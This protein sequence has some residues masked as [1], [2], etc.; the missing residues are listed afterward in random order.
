MA[1][2]LCIEYPGAFCDVTCGGNESVAKRVW[3]EHH[4]MIVKC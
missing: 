4:D 1:G 3:F 2:P